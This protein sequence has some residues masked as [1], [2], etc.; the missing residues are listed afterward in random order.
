[1]ATDVLRAHNILMPA[2][3]PQR[4]RAAAAAHRRPAAGSDN[5]HHPGATRRRSQPVGTSS[6]AAGRR[7]RGRKMRSAVEVYAGPGFSTSP[8][9]SSLP[10][11]QF[12]TTRKAVAAAAVDAAAAATRDLR[13]ILRLE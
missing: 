10:L 13:L 12:P 11:P 8:D 7:H 3:P 2:P 9:P 1:M 5:H 6:P 4:I